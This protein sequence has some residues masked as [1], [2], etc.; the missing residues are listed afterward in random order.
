[1]VKKSVG[2]RPEAYQKLRDLAEEIS[3]KRGVRVTLAQVIEASLEL[4]DRLESM[5]DEN[6]VEGFDAATADRR[7]FY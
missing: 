5:Q 7:I 2:L 4:V 6:D 1:M 3:R